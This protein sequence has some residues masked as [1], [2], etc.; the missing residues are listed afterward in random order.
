MFA[1]TGGKHGTRRKYD[2]ID[3]VRRCRRPE[4][5]TAGIGSFRFLLLLLV[6]LDALVRLV[7]GLVV[8]GAVDEEGGFRDGALQPEGL[9][10]VAVTNGDLVHDR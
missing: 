5:T 7:D 3:K 9:D 6:P 8:M 2:D 1:C 10:G 4:M